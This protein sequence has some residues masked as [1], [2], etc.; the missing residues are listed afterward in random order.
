L[1]LP[2]DDDM[3]LDVGVTNDSSYDHFQSL[4]R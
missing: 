1:L 2:R 3:I 4:N